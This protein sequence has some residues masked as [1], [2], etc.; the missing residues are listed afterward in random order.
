LASAPPSPSSC[1]AALL[2]IHDLELSFSGPM[3]IASSA[4]R[5]TADD[6]AQDYFD[7]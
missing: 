2:P 6:N 4:M 3:H 5:D 7:T 1:A